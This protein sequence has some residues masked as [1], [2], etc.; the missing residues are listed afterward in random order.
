MFV[1]GC[2]PKHCRGRTINNNLWHNQLH[3]KDSVYGSSTAHLCDYPKQEPPPPM[4]TK[5]PFPAT[6]DNV[7]ALRQYL[8]DRY[9]SS[10]FNTFEHRKLPL[11]TGPPMQLVVDP[12]AKPVAYHTPVPVPLHWQKD[13]STVSEQMD[14]PSI[15]CV[16]QDL[17]AV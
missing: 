1:K 2:R 3:K 17:I 5:L 9:K 15:I 4:P 16:L 6:E 12:E 8:L 13:G 14:P 11:M 10:T 7:M